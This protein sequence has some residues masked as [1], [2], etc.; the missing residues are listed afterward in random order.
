MNVAVKQKMCTSDVGFSHCTADGG[1]VQPAGEAKMA[2]GHCLPT[3]LRLGFVLHEGVVC[4]VS[5]RY[6]AIFGRDGIVA[7]HVAMLFNT[8]GF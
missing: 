2:D 1:D 4:L 7:L 8:H 3:Q 5:R 6:P